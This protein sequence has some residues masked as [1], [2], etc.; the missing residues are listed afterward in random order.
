[1]KFAYYIYKMVR[2]ALVIFATFIFLSSSIPPV[3]ILAKW[4]LPPILQE[5]SGIAYIDK[6]RF[7]C[8]QDEQGIIF[9]YNTATRSIEREITFAPPG[10]Y[11]GICLVGEDAWVVRSDGRIFRVD[12]IH[13]A[14]PR[15]DQFQSGFLLRQE[16]EGI[17]YDKKSNGL[18]LS[19]KDVAR[20]DQTY[21]AIYRFDLLTK[22]MSNDPFIRI[23]LQNEAFRNNNKKGPIFFPSDI[24]MHPIS[25]EIYITDASRSRLLIM[26]ANGA[27]RSVVQLSAS[28]FSQPEGICFDPAGRMFISNEGSR[29]PANILS[30]VID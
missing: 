17:C 8:I 3:R 24:S 21:K 13:S 10:D 30:V 4:D 16:I 20:G 5:I 11:E 28:E 2:V 15:T 9:I 1:M 7:A 19:V 29:S 18:L 27:I 12:S 6:D 23:D 25:D 22:T 26:N 14:Q